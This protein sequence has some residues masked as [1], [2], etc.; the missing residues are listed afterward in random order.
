MA[1]ALERIT[2][3]VPNWV[4]DRI[5]D[6]WAVLENTSTR[7]VISVHA[8]KIPD[9]AK[10]GDTLLNYKSKWLINLADTKARA[11]RVKARF[12]QVKG[13]SS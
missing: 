8:T 10:P 5:E 6:G 12:S 13:R 7:E 11:E 2:R 3:L 9:R 1:M 4:I